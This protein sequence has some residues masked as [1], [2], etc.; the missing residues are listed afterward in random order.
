MFKSVIA[1]GFLTASFLSGQA[2]AQT[3]EEDRQDLEDL[4]NGVG[5][6]GQ[7]RD[8]KT[9]ERSRKCNEISTGGIKTRSGLYSDWKSEKYGYIT[10][11]MVDWSDPDNSD[12]WVNIPVH[13]VQ[14]QQKKAGCG[15]FVEDTDWFHHWGTVKIKVGI[16][17]RGHLT[18][19]NTVRDTHSVC[20]VGVLHEYFRR[21]DAA[22]L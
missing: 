9:T 12:Y 5:A 16:G 10:V 6:S 7:Y 19:T 17:R 8:G 11:T 22:R 21:I 4:V 14:K 1:A 20:G 15:G 18:T 3:A 2:L 13:C